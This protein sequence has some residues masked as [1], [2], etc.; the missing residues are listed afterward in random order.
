MKHWVE[1][2]QTRTDDKGIVVREEPNGWCL[3]E[4]STPHNRI[5]IPASL[6]N[7]AYF[8]HVTCI[9]ADVA[10]IL[11]K[12]E[13]EHHLH[14]LAETIRKNFNAAFTMT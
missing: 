14:T 11:D 7:T 6:V 12:K 4:W 9:M 2:L 10:G 8:Y 5:E 3:G 13:D 1:Y